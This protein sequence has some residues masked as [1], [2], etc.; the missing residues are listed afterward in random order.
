MRRHL[1][2]VAMTSFCLSACGLAGQSSTAG[3]AV[4]AADEEQVFEGPVTRAQCGAGSLPETDMQGRVSADDRASGRSLMP[5]TCNTEL[6]GTTGNGASW[7]HAWYENCA[8]YGTSFQGGSSTG[9]KVVDATDPK[10]P[11][12]T[13][14]LTSLAMLDPWESLKANEKRGLLG[15]VSAYSG[16]DSPTAFDVY[17]LTGDCSKPRLLSSLPIS[18]TGHEGNW[19]PDGRTYYG[20]GLFVPEI[21]AIDTSDPFHPKPIMVIP[22]VTH[23]LDASEDGN[24]L[25][26]AAYIGTNPTSDGSTATGNGLEIYDSTLLNSRQPAEAA[27]L[28][29]MPTLLGSVYWSDGSTAQ[30]PIPVTI[31]G[32]KYVIFVDEG[33]NGMAR[34]I[35]INDDAHPFVIA[36]LKLEIDMPDQAASDARS[37]DTGTG[38]FAYNGHYCGVDSRQEPTIL[39]CSYFWSGVRFFDIR[40]PHHPRE[41]AYYNP[42]GADG[43]P[44]SQNGTAATNAGYASAQVRFVKERGEAWFTDQN[45]GFMIVKFTNGVW[46]FKD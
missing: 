8:Y 12:I 11:V 30:H 1:A 18:G 31:K 37:E 43:S 7:Q 44:E 21:M 28:P 38:S 4:T 33:G 13:Q 10:K 23:G 26:L 2:F 45:H 27:R 39:G 14:S 41:I 22:R 35:D 29:V 19:A 34:I 15:A 46:P 24:R 36:K 20:A 32:K 25:Y 6:V 42:G 40:D 3:K 5:Y 9:V 16:L 17:D